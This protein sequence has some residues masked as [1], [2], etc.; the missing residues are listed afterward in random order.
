MSA[1]FYHNDEQKDLAIETMKFEQKSRTR[2]IT[3]SVL[4]AKE[5]YVAEE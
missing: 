2:P 4:P 5:F 3:T 1:I